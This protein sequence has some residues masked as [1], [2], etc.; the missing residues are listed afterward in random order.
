MIKR[1]FFTFTKPGFTYE[2]LTDTLAPPRPV[3]LPSAVTLY[4]DKPFAQKDALKLKSGTPVKT[5]ER[6]SLGGDAGPAVISPVS[7]SIQGLTAYTGDYGRR[8]TAVTIKV[9]KDEPV[10]EG[11][12]PDTPVTLAY[13][14]R[15]F[16]SAPGAPPLAELAD[17]KKTVS[18]LVIYGGDAD[19]L[20]HTN[21]YVAKT[22]SE[23]LKKG[24][25]VLREATE[26]EEIVIALP[27]E[28]LQGHEYPDVTVINVP[29]AYPNAQPLMVLYK[30]LG[31]S[32]PSDGNAESLGVLFMR[33]EA[34]AAIG[35]AYLTGR[36]TTD[37]LVT[38]IDKKGNR[39]LASVR[40]GTPVSQILKQFKIEVAEGDRLIFGGPMTGSAIYSEDQPIM[41]DT[42]ALLVQDAKDVSVC[43]DYP[44]INCGDCIRICPAAIQVPMLVRFLE[45]GQYEE[46]ADLY[47]LFSCVECG[48]CSFVCSSRIPILQYIKLGKFEL[49]HMLTAEEANE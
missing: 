46:A 22:R 48:L 36:L 18:K 45:A 23:A 24:I 43:S 11:F 44:C 8:L 16:A 7:G 30:A 1:S 12:D 20:T 41:A 15:Y 28:T 40:L 10:E 13:L 3:P 6:L 35:S 31:Y 39:T 2:E 21:Q 37:K 4:I 32:V 19:L 38:V 42:D 27:G 5:G 14:R 29:A 47:D 17:E 33:A 49:A 26:L 25:A 9:D 34:V